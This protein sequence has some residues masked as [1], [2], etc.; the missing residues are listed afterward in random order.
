[1][2]KLGHAIDYLADEFVHAGGSL[3]AHDARL[4]AMQ[5]LIA[6][7]REI[8]FSCPPVPGL[9]ERRRAL[10]LARPF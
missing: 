1:L 5:I 8:Y 3:T 10:L 2:E 6:A 9:M 4:E 7:N